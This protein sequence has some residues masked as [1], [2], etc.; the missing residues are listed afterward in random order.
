VGRGS[1]EKQTHRTAGLLALKHAAEFKYHFVCI[2]WTSYCVD[3]GDCARL[4]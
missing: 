2:M 4:A 1:T 3:G